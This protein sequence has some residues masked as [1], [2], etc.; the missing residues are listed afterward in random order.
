MIFC[1]GC[2][3]QA[4]HLN[5]GITKWE[6]LNIKYGSVIQWVHEKHGLGK[7]NGCKA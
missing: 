7:A 6:A 4:N 3:Q 5:S 1:V 2:L